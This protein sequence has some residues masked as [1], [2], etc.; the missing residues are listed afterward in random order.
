MLH[1]V[2]IVKPA[3]IGVGHI[4]CILTS[5]NGASIKAIAFRVGDNQIGNAMLAQKSEKFDVVGVLKHDRWNGKQDAV[6]FIIEDIRPSCQ[7]N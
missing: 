4:R 6:Q 5:E 7:E 3:L 2:R 1:R